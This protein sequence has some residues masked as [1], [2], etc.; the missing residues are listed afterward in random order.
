MSQLHEILNSKSEYNRCALPRL[1]T[2]LGNE[3]FE[4]W[5][6]EKLKEKRKENKIEEKIR[7][8]TG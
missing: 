7:R 3:D 6:E 2:K 8:E 1:T 5:K 4:K